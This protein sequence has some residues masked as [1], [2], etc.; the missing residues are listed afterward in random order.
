[1]KR[2]FADRKEVAEAMEKPTRQ[3]PLIVSYSYS[4]HTHRIAQALQAVT[5]GDWC[6]IYPWQPY[7]MGFSELLEQVRR[8]VRTGYRPR[9]LP[10]AADAGPYRVLFVGAPNWCGAI[11]PPM[12]SW[13]A[14]QDLAGKILLPFVSHCGGVP[15]DFTREITRLCPKADVRAALEVLDDGG[16][17]LFHALQTWLQ[18]N[19][20]GTMP[21]PVPAFS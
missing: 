6:E 20:M 4:G 3:C 19:R 7:P 1:M 15:C 18:E 8:E 11:A 14:K 13:L 10:G 5:G 9:L 2:R 21:F 12:V 16:E 17:G